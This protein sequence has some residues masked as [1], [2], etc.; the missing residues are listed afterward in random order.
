[1]KKKTKKRILVIISIL[2][3][4][5][6]YLAVGTMAPFVKYKKLSEESLQWK[7]EQV[8]DES[9]DYGDRAKLVE[10]NL[11]AW[12]ERIRMLSLAKERIIFV[13]FD[14][15]DG[16]STTDI[17]SMLLHKAQEG[18]EVSILIDGFNGY[19]NLKGNA[20]Y[21]AV[22]SHPNVTSKLY[23][24]PNVLLPWKWQ[25]RMHDKYIIIDNMLYMLGGRNT[26]EY[27]ISKKETY[28]YDREV[29]VYN[30]DYQ[31][32]DNE[33]EEKSSLYTLLNYFETIYE[34]DLCKS[35]EDKE[36]YAKRKRV[37]KEIT[38]LEERYETLKNDY[39]YLFEEYNYQEHTHETEG[40]A[41]LSNPTH[42]YGKE[43]IAFHQVTEM[44]KL[45]KERAIIHTP[46]IVCNEYMYDVVEELAQTVDCY[47]LINSVANGDNIVASSDY[48]KNKGRLI[49]TGMTIYEF[50]GGKSS[51]G[52][53]VLIDSDISIIGSLNWD[54]R[55]VY[56]DTELM[57]AVKSKGLN[58][59]LFREMQVFKDNSRKVISENEYETPEDVT[60]VEMEKTK[61]MVVKLLGV[62]LGKF[63]FLI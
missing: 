15:R 13:T 42:I 61:R 56:M 22:A 32:K 18:V 25:G 12:E 28:S 30:A 33:K 14:M 52:K 51:H 41:L 29:L 7:A 21:Q 63:R 2:I 1:M 60:P 47:M 43:P 45:A 49:E 48:M 40:V 54:L 36:T 4:I 55:S 39:A 16:E 46:Y 37:K 26:F 9:K 35:F 10:S 38:R 34:G 31:K 6:L 20:L 23:N 59:D 24:T 27:F 44:I 53:S 58:E 3:V 57:I 19:K 5:I 62:V 11:S 50:E 8:F 17:L